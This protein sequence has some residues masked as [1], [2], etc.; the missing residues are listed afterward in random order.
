MSYPP[1]RERSSRHVIR[2]AQLGE[3]I[4][5]LTLGLSDSIVSTGRTK[6]PKNDGKRKRKRG[7]EDGNTHTTEDWGFHDY[8]LS[9][10][11]LG[12]R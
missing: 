2:R 6:G 12:R 4:T 10:G 7:S 9:M 11:A 8:R 3:E 1:P 5:Q